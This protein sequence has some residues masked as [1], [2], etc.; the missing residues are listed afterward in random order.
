MKKI[1]LAVA[2]LTTINLWA[3]S[4]VQ[5]SNAIYQP[6]ASVTHTEARPWKSY[7]AMNINFRP[8]AAL[9]ERVDRALPSGLNQ[10]NRRTEAHITVISPVEYDRVLSRF[11]SISE[12][13]RIARAMKIQS[14]PF[15]VLCLAESMAKIDGKQEKTYY[16]VV[17]SERLLQIRRAIYNLFVKR[18]GHPSQFDPDFFYPHITVGYTKDDLHFGQHG[19]H[20][21]ARSC[22]ARINWI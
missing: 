4:V 15:K 16:L 8:V 2:L 21:N 7:L 17:S 12:I 18:G 1:L 13:H 22:V 19:V 20:K 11:V 14:S 6:E 10:S 3:D 9:F 5:L